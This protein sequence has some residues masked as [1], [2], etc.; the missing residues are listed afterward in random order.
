MPQRIID[1]HILELLEKYKGR[2]LRFSDI[3]KYFLKSKT[4]HNQSNI[5]SNLLFLLEQKKIVKV[6]GLTRNF[7]GL[8]LTREEDGSKYL[9]VTQGI[10]EEELEVEK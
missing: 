7:Y 9:I 8:P 10:E 5:W 1:K 6:R 2:G 3:F 4:L